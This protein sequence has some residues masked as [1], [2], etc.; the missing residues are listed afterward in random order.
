[1][2]EEQ[3]NR[4]RLAA[5]VVSCIARYAPS[6]CL[7][8]LTSLFFYQTTITVQMVLAHTEINKCPEKSSLRMN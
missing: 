8:A 7:A 5:L 4:A 1:M 2:G 3:N 6:S